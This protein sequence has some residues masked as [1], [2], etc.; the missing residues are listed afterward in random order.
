MQIHVSSWVNDFRIAFP[1]SPR[2][3]TVAPVATSSN[4]YVTRQVW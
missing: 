3:V 1:S 4:N 2:P